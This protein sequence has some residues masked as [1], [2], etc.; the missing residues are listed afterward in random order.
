MATISESLKTQVKT[1]ICDILE[2]DPDDVSETSRFI[3]DH[4]ADSLQAIEILANLERDLGVTLDQ[5][6]LGRMTTLHEVYAVLA[7]AGAR[8]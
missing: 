6:D 1:I 3:E 2:L 7:E 8:I 4:G 5:S